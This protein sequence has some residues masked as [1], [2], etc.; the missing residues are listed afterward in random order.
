[1]DVNKLESFAS[2]MTDI[3][4]VIAIDSREDALRL[5]EQN[6]GTEMVRRG[7]CVALPLKDSSVDCVTALDVIEHVEADRL[8]VREFARVFKARRHHRRNR[9]GYAPCCGASGTWRC[10]IIEDITIQVC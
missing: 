6:I 9:S 2:E 8:A 5:V 4:N 1:L 3:C 7:S 10:T